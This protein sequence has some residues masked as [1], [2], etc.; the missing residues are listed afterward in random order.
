MPIPNCIRYVNKWF[1]NRIM[2]LLAG[3]KHSPI[4]LVAHVGRRSGTTYRT[5]IMVER[6]ANEFVFA[7]TYGPRVDWYRNVLAAGRCELRW[8]GKTY[9]LVDPVAISQAEGLAVYP[10]PQRAILKKMNLSS[11]FKMK[12]TPDGQ[13]G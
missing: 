4:A 11:F 7:L 12:I 5:P 8:H 9:P 2:I 6:S 13:S 3:K 10:N 1:T